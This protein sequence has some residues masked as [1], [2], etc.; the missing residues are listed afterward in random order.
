MSL[1]DALDGLL[2]PIEGDGPPV[3]PRR[4]REALWRPGVEWKGEEGTLTTPAGIGDAHPDWAHVLAVWDLDPERF[5]V[6][7][8]VLFNAWDAPGPEGAILRMKQWK[9]RVIRRKQDT[10]PTLD[11]EQLLADALKAKPAKPAPPGEG[12][13]HVVLGDWQIGKSDGDGLR[14]TVTR[15]RQAIFDVEGRVRELRRIGRPLGTLFVEWTGDSVE[16]CTGFYAMQTFGVELDRREQTKVTRRLLRDALMRWSRLFDSVVVLAVGGNH[17]EQRN[18]RGKAFTTFGDNDD[19]AIVEQVGEVLAGN[20]DAFGH[21]R[22]VIPPDHL[23]VTAEAAGWIVG[24]THGH[25]SRGS[26]TAEI[27]LRRWYEQAAGGKQPV[28]DADILVTGHY[29]HLRVADWG[30][31]VWAQC[32]ALDG[33]SEWWRMTSG[34]SSAPGVLTFASY[35]ERRMTDIAVL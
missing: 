33:G 9:A 28:G 34:E 12:V 10:S 8:P 17:G 4:E 24:V 18:S 29:H 35:P 22:I 32:P 26:G 2:D 25:V 14:G 3:V 7:E 27:K 30:G 5:A 31:C 15:I 11:V 6:V 16:G 1:D 23:A 21:V 13:F 19:L 20:P